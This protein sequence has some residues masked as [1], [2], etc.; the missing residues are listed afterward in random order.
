MQA[1]L[2]AVQFVPRT[3]LISQ[4]LERHR[5]NCEWRWSA[6]LPSSRNWLCRSL[7]FIPPQTQMQETAFSAVDLCIELSSRCWHFPP[8]AGSDS[9]IDGGHLR[10]RV[11][12]YFEE[13]A[14]D[15]EARKLDERAG[16]Y[17]TA[18]SNTRNRVPGAICT[19]NAVSCV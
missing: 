14:G 16:D 6:L 2:T 19:E 3:H 9:E 17:C 1:A 4:R 10:F 8:A 13:N 7:P 12:V 5:P 11:Q 15:W 18:N